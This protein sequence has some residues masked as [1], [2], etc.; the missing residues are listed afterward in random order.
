MRLVDSPRSTMNELPAIVIDASVAVSIVRDESEGSAAAIAVDRWTRE[1]RRIVTPSHF[2]LEVVNSLIRRHRWPTSEVVRALRDLDE[3][4][5]ETVELDR[6]L[7]L[8]AIDFAERH[9]LTSYDAMYLALADAVEGSLM[10]FDRRLRAAA[11]GRAIAPGSHR[12]SEA[13][14]PYEHDVTWPNYKGASA[15]LAKLRAEALRDA[16]T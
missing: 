7:L 15:Y 4:E 13:S 14:S 3:M 1:R 2:W 16:S 11:G 8:S 6:A 10:T 5:L 9:S 12:L